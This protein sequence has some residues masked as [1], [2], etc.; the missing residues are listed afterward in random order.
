MGRGLRPCYDRF[1]AEPGRSVMI[2]PQHILAPD[3]P[4]AA[5]LGRRFEVR[6]QQQR[7]IEAVRQ[8]LAGGEQQVI[9]AG[10]GVGK[11]FAYL[12]AA[13]ERIVD[14][15]EENGAEP[16]RQRVV[17]ST[18]TIALQEQ[19]IERDIPL[20]QS[21]IDEVFSPVLVKG[22]SN[23]V[24]IRRLAS[25][26]QRQQRL[27]TDRRSLKS[28]HTIEDWAYTTSDGSLA[29]LPQLHSP[30]VW[31]RV[32]SDSGNCMGRRCPTYD[33]CFYQNARRRME[34]GDLLVVNHALF[35][36]D[37]A[38]RSAGVGFLPPYDHVILDEAHTVEDV[39]ADHFGLR[40]SEAK[41]RLL[42][43]AL[44][45]RRTGKGF[46]ATLEPKADHA[47]TD[48]ALQ[49]VVDGEYAA[50]V[51]FDALEQYHRSHLQGSGR[52]SEANVVENV[53]SEALD[54]MSLCL[55]AMRDKVDSEADRFELSG[56]ASRCDEAAA[57]LKALIE[58][59]QPASVYW[60]ECGQKG[61]TRRLALCCCPVDVGPLLR[62]RLFEAKGPT[63][64]PLG[65]VLTSATLATRTGDTLG[66]DGDDANPFEHIQRRLGCPQ[67]KTLLLGSP[68]DYHR[69]AQ[70]IIRQDM[71]QPNDGKFTRY[72]VPAIADCVRGS[73]G[74]AFVLFTSY[75]LLRTAAE[76]LGPLLAAQELTMLVQGQGEQRTTLLER[77]RADGNAVLLGTDS[78]WQGVDVQGSALRSVIITRL[79][80]AVPDR[81]LIEARMQLI[82]SRG[83]NAFMEYSLPEAVLKFKQGF[84]RLIRSRDDHGC[85]VVLDSRIV[86]KPYGRMFIE[87][88]PQLPVQI[89]SSH[90]APEAEPAW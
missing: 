46:L 45:H 71:P 4:I 66:D 47:L 38:L 9:E 87:A 85:V 39:A 81:P 16:R 54:V 14:P 60:L 48:R 27:F 36:S 5:R 73:E 80:F 25:A 59:S 65:V 78:F 67:A 56:Y 64:D 37:L 19:L 77:F 49:A 11:S 76:A 12:L 18:H 3:G 42:L 22:R 26:S 70:L 32:M 41:V 6:P 63:G 79:P 51:F 61:R 10:T 28:L 57:Q 84:G 69:Q 74:G 90:E 29:T 88:L 1:G 44:R 13:I 55:K 17:V 2:D 33:K 62:E 86:T 72:L 82:K 31:D 52:L 35:F 23:Y 58:Q 24:S 43:G 83:G 21:V 7:M 89:A 8:C 34:R 15:H 50:D 20:L 53:L 40:V 75:S 30:A 68:F